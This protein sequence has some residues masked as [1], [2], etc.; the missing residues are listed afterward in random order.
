MTIIYI[1]GSLQIQNI[2]N[3]LNGSDQSTEQ[4]LHFVEKCVALQRMLQFIWTKL[5]PFNQWLF[6][7]KFKLAQWFWKR[8]SKTMR[9]I[10]QYCYYL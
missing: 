10:L 8:L 3:G 6:C 4:Q 5:N 2:Y 1:D 7:A 9:V